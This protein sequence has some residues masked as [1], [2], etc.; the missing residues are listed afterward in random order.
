MG[1]TGYRLVDIA[2]LA[3]QVPMQYVLQRV[4]IGKG[5]GVTVVSDIRVASLRIS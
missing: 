5:L 3:G 2:Y 4:P 1:L